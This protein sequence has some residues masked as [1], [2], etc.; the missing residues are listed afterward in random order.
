MC[1]INR[2]KLKK[3]S[4]IVLFVSIFIPF[5]FEGIKVG[6]MT[7][8]I[9]RIVTPVLLMYCLY[10]KC[11]RLSYKNNNILFRWIVFLLCWIILGSLLLGFS[12]YIIIKLAIKELLSLGNAVI[13]L[14]I[15]SI[16]IKNKGEL[17]FSFKVIRVLSI[18]MVLFGIIEIITGNHYVN[19]IY[20]N[21]E[22]INLKYISKGLQINNHMATG[23]LYGVNDFASFI[24]VF[25]PFIFIK[26]EA[27]FD[28]ICNLIILGLSIVILYAND[29]NIVLLAVILGEFI[30]MFLNL[31][32]SNFK[33]KIY[34]VAG[35]L[36]LLILAIYSYFILSGKA[37]PKKGVISSQL[38]NYQLNQGS[39]FARITIY[40]EAFERS[41]KNYFMGYGP[42]SFISYF[43]KYKSRSGLVNPH[44]LAFEI[45]FNYGGIVLVFFCRQIYILI[46]KN[47]AF[48]IQNREK[49]S[50]I[51]LNSLIVY[52]LVSFS[53]SSFLAYSYQWLVIGMACLTINV[54]FKDYEVYRAS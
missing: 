49:E 6:G 7:L 39:L 50:L 28:K 19:S 32:K 9:Q 54:T 14:F 44:G 11:G 41:F 23:F 38:E 42:A 5:S 17:K 8:T 24:G 46:K 22:A 30:Y 48:Y 33:K 16:L 1:L 36:I 2:S 4:I 29:A 51:I 31:I 21:E 3:V 18:F 34:T 52:I 12:D 53:P 10:V 25:L 43:T 15:L 20:Y 45:L 35:V 26:N 27:V 37:V 13:I 40:K 47:L